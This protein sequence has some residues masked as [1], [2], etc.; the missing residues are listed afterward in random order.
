MERLSYGNWSSE[1]SVRS[2]EDRSRG[3]LLT[4]TIARPP[5]TVASHAAM[6]RCERCEWFGKSRID[7][8]SQF[9]RGGFVQRG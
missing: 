3:K 9:R 7:V 2:Q 6:R 5:P 8:L 4:V 1:V